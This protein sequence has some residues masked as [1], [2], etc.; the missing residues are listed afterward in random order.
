[1]NTNQDEI[2][3]SA[4]NKKPEI[5]MSDLLSAISESEYPQYILEAVEI[6]RNWIHD[7][8]SKPDEEKETENTDIFAEFFGYMDDDESGDLNELFSKLGKLEEFANIV[9]SQ[10]QDDSKP[11]TLIVSLANADCESGLRSAIDYAAIFNRPNCKR[12]WIISDTFIFDEIIKFVPHVEALLE[13]GISLRF[14]LV[15]AW[16]WVELPLSEKAATKNQFLWKTLEK[17][18]KQK[19]RKQ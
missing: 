2:Q 11:E 19:K 6:I 12:V 8:I 18:S 10:N 9:P 17:N 5:M 1:M 3:R 14:I 7:A 16:G 15:T 4:A 13:Q